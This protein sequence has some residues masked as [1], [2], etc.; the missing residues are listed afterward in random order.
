MFDDLLVL[1]YACHTDNIK[2]VMRHKKYACQIQNKIIHYSAVYIYTMSSSID[3]S[4]ILTLESE[5]QNIL[6]GPVQQ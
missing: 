5:I 3:H 2:L 4:K 6:L 1:V